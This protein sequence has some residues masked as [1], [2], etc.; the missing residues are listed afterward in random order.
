MED[1]TISN[2]QL[3]LQFSQITI[4]GKSSEYSGTSNITI[5]CKSPIKTLSLDALPTQIKINE[6][7]IQ[8]G[9]YKV[10]FSIES[11]Q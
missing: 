7:N 3:K 8:Q 5:D 9:K 1:F 4:Q 2:Y 11:C 10:K 6:A